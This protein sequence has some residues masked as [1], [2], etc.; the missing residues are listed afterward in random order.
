ML[1]EKMPQTFANH[2]RF[3]PMFH[4]VTFGLLIVNLVYRIYKPFRMFSWGA[5]VDILLAV[6]LVLLALFVRL[7]AA[8]LQDRIIRLEMRQ[9]LAR[10][11]PAELAARVGELREGQL[12]A[13]RFASDAELP[14]L[15]ADV[16]AGKLQRQ[17]EIKQ[18][19]QAWEP[20]YFRV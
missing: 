7:F 13:L 5:I 6:A 9:R 10:V 17:S 8:R 14:G 1:G 18:R 16:L 4:F 11:L 12:V 3:V 20:D 15:V 2:A 19:I